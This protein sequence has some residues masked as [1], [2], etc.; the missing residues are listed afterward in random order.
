MQQFKKKKT[1]K[2]TPKPC[3]L[4]VKFIWNAKKENMLRAHKS[5]PLSLTLA[6]T[7]IHVNTRE[8]GGGERVARDRHGYR[9]TR[10]NASQVKAF[11]APIHKYP[12]PG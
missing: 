8:D 1:A 7:L 12:L 9:P 3:A 5:Y 11:S 4:S 10:V 2:K 6:Y